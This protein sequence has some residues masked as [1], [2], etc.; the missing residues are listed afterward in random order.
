MKKGGIFMKSSTAKKVVAMYTLMIG[1]L[2]IFNSGLEIISEVSTISI[3]IS[4]TLLIGSALLMSF[5]NLKAERSLMMGML[6]FYFLL[7]FGGL[8]YIMMAPLISFIIFLIGGLPVVFI[9]IYFSRLEAE[10]GE[11]SSTLDNGSQTKAV[12]EFNHQDNGEPSCDDIKKTLKHLSEMVKDGL[13]TQ[14]DYNEK[15]RELLKLKDA[16]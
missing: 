10:K 4:I 9:N 6:F 11:M 15:K 5:N 1:V 12:D 7:I 3:Y 14:S 8:I 13:I 2:F 16:N